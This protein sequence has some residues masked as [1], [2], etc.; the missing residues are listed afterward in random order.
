MAAY[1]DDYVDHFGLREKIAFRT[2]VVEVEPVDG[3]WE[4]TVE[5]A[6]GEASDRTATAPCWSPTATTGTRAGPNPPSPASEEFEGE[7]MHAHHYRE[8]DVLRGKRVL[9]LG[10]G[11][12]AIDIAVESSR[13]ADKTF[14][15]IRRGAYVIPKYINGKPIDELAEPD[16]VDDCRWRCSASSRS[17]AL[18]VA[19]AGD[20]TAYGLPKP[21]HKLLRGP[22]DGLLG[23]AAPARPRRHRGQAQHRP[24][25]RRP[26]GPLRRRQRG[27]DR[28]RRLLHRLQDRPSPSSTRRCSPRPTTAC[29]STGGSSRS[30][31]PASTSSASSS[32][33][34]R[35]CRSP[36]PSA[37]GSPT[38]SRGRATLP[39]PAEMRAEIA[40]EE[41]RDAK[42]LRRL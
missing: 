26:H 27:G 29:R 32:P 24:L 3:E 15:A 23:A 18:G 20:P 37:N 36:R 12:S 11:N 31:A 25:H 41:R 9:V 14:L 42:A 28:P 6:D 30:S 39:P 34:G 5:D 13:I 38:C 21:D 10:I 33:W 22:P 16:H 1:F 35:S 8:P 2:E 19:S 17:R 4:V 7:Q 40:R